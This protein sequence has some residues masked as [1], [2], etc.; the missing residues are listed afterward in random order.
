[1]KFSPLDPNILITTGSDGKFKVWDIRDCGYRSLLTGEGSDN[2]LN[3]ATFNNVNKNL[4]ACGGEDTGLIGVWDLR[5]PKM[6]INDLSH[7][8]K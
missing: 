5:L 6:C 1:V 3:C 8:S 2:D 4:F 7:H